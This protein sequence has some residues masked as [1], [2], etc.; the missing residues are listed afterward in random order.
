VTGPR[1]LEVVRSLGPDQLIDYSRED[2]TRRGER[3]DVVFDVAATRSLRDCLRVL[4]PGGALIQ[5]GAPKNGLAS[6]VGR[7][8]LTVIVKRF[9]SRRIPWLLARVT[10]EDLAMLQELVET[11]KIVPVIDREFGF[12]AVPEA[13]RYVKSGQG[14]AKVV[15][16]V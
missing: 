4:V 14:R 15:I 13:I 11:G 16:T 10:P 2:F 12:D 7:L 8:A 9:S 6:V 1:N 3:F 5:A